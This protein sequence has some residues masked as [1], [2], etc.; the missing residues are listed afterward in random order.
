VKKKPLAPLE[1]PSSRSLPEVPGT[2]LATMLENPA[3]VRK[4]LQAALAANYLP[5]GV[6]LILA[7]EV[8]P[9]DA[10][11]K[12]G[13]KGLGTSSSGLIASGFDHLAGLMASAIAWNKEHQRSFFQRLSEYPGSHA[14]VAVFRRPSAKQIRGTLFHVAQFVFQGTETVPVLLPSGVKYDALVLPPDGRSQDVSSTYKIRLSQSTEEAE[15]VTFSEKIGGDREY[16]NHVASFIPH[17]NLVLAAP[18]VFYGGADFQRRLGTMGLNVL[19]H[20]TVAIDRELLTRVY[21]LAD[22][23]N[24][25]FHISTAARL[26]GLLTG[27]GQALGIVEHSLKNARLHRRTGDAR[28]DAVLDAELLNVRGARSLLTRSSTS[29]VFTA[30]TA[31]T[32]DNAL[33]LYGD[34]DTFDLDTEDLRGHTVSHAFVALLIEMARNQQ[35]GGKKDGRLKVTVSEDGYATIVTSTRCACA[36]A[37][38]LR[39]A[40]KRGLP[41]NGETTLEGTQALL[42]LCD[43]LSSADSV[44][45]FEVDDPSPDQRVAGRCSLPSHGA[46]VTCRFGEN[47]ARMIANGEDNDVKFESRTR[48]TG[49]RLS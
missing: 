6:L 5:N 40:V 3:Y 26:D 21:L 20:P 41:R 31:R 35:K 4:E 14:S 8:T 47:L 23:L 24:A 2:S 16:L 36:D 43:F 28:L 10:E 13:N 30:D 25:M 1:W 12:I 11:L 49:L 48:I 45:C 38:K 46:V 7:A 15:F 9:V 18:R 44:V 39:D 29:E 34:G 37:K 27:A 19:F 42:I 22:R 32:L 33:S 17:A